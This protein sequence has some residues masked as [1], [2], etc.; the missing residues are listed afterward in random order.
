MLHTDVLTTSSSQIEVFL[1]CLH[2]QDHPHLIY[3][4]RVLHSSIILDFT[5]FFYPL[6]ILTLPR[7]LVSSNAPTSLIFCPPTI[8]YLKVV[9]DSFDSFRFHLSLLALY[10][11]F[12]ITYLR[13]IFHD[14]L[15]LSQNH[16][17]IVIFI[18]RY[19]RF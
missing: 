17:H 11:A 13:F 10:E 1:C 6:L 3:E 12:D 9:L 5:A 18:C 8:R 15:L 19:L 16:F 4:H 7:L 2:A 14:H